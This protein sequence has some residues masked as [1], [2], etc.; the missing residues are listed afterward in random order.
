[1][2]LEGELYHCIWLRHRRFFRVEDHLTLRGAL[3]ALGLKGETLQAA[4]LRDEQ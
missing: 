4:G 3:R 1:M 2:R